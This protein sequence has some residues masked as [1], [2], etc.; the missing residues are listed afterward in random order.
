MSSIRKPSS[1]RPA[2]RSCQQAVIKLNLSLLT[3]GSVLLAHVQHGVVQG[4][5]HE[6]L[7]TEVVDT[8]R[9]AVCLTL[10][11][12]VPIKNQAVTESQTGGRVGSMFVA[13]EHG[14]GKGGLDMTDNLLLEAI[15][16]SESTRLVALPCFALGFGNRSY[17]ESVS[18][19][20][21]PYRLREQNARDREQQE[22]LTRHNGTKAPEKAG[23]IK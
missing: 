7:K 5:A 2:A 14:T 6:E 1:A 21:E 10:L 23:L 17:S 19:S 20:L 13:V 16:A 12:S 8:L 9:I 11:S 4:A 22:P 3:L 15:F 18:E